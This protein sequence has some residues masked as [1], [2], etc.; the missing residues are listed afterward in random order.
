MVLSGECL[1]V[2]VEQVRRY[3]III[4]KTLRSISQSQ[5]RGWRLN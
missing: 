2:S 3:Q 4:R 5:M 1:L